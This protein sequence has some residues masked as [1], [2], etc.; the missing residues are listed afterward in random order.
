M[1]KQFPKTF[2]KYNLLFVLLLLVLNVLMFV[3]TEQSDMRLFERWR[4]VFDFDSEKNIPTIY[5]GISIVFCSFLLHKIYSESDKTVS[6]R[7]PWF[8]LSVI[9]LFLAFDEMFEIHERL[10]VPVKQTFQVSGFL[11]YAWVIPYGIALIVLG[12]AL[13]KFLYE[14]PRNILYLFVVAGSIFVMGALGLEMIGG[15]LVTLDSSSSYL[16]F[17]LTTIEES[18]EMVGIAIFIFALFSYRMEYQ[19]AG[20]PIESHVEE[21]L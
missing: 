8:L 10:M 2:F 9:F 18:L 16:F 5:S 1:T 4:F 21:H 13:L 14:L 17:A 11:H 7:W 6:P 12:I 15:K 3:A 19:T 20:S